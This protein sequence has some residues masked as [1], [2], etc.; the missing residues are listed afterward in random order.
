MSLFVRLMQSM[1]WPTDVMSV[2]L[3]EGEGWMDMVE[4]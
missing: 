1:L 2:V 4:G 3:D